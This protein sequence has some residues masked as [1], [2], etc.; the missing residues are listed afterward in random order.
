VRI[1]KPKA[2][3]RLANIR[4]ATKP[5][6][7]DFGN[8]INDAAHSEDAL[9]GPFLVVA[10]GAFSPRH[11]SDLGDILTTLS[12]D[13]GSLR[14]RDDGSDMDPGGLVMGS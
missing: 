8:G 6:I 5:G 14:T 2:Y 7:T 1:I 4:Q 10:H 11:L 13:G 3:L 9:D 12:N